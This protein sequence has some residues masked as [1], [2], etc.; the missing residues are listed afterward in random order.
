MHSAKSFPVSSIT[1]RTLLSALSGIPVLALA[2]CAA[3]GGDESGDPSPTDRAESRTRTDRTSS[4]SPTDTSL[5]YATTVDLH[6]A[7]VPDEEAIQ[8]LA[9]EDL[10]ADEQDIIRAAADGGYAVRHGRN[11]GIPDTEKAEG[12]ESLIDRILDRLETQQRAY[13]EDHDDVPDYVHAVYVRYDGWLY[14]IAL[15]RGDTRPYDC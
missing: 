1:R 8:P 9:Y 15:H 7:S 13:R 10:P 11:E 4:P 3:P 2:G 5:T 12:L 14:C 6:L